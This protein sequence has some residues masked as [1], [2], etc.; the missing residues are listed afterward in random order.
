M[1]IE[2][3]NDTISNS[4]D[5]IDITLL[6]DLDPIIGL[7]RI[8]DNQR[9]TNRFDEQNIEYHKSIQTAYHQLRD[10]SEYGRIFT[11]DASQTEEKILEDC[12]SKINE[13]LNEGD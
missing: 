1:E 2:N 13:K 5:L 7:N 9:E 6:F 10:S 3:M 4:K 12:I 8:N 11:I